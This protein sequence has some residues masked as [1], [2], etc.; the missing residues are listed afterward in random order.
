MRTSM[1]RRKARGS[2]VRWTGALAAVAVGLAAGQSAAQDW[3]WLGGSSA[4][5]SDLANWNSAA[6]GSGSA[7]ASTAALQNKTLMLW[8]TKPNLPSNQDIESLAVSQ[9]RFDDTVTSFTITGQPIQLNDKINNTANPATAQTVTFNNVV[10]L[11]STSAWSVRGNTRF[12]LVGGMQEVGGSRYFSANDGGRIGFF[13]PVTTTGGWRNNQATA[14]FHGMETLGTFPATLNADY[15]RTGYG[16]MQF[17]SPDGAPYEYELPATVGGRSTTTLALNVPTDVVVIFHGP[18][19]EDAANRSVTKWGGGVLYL[20]GTNTFTGSISL[21][22]GMLVLGGPLSAGDG[23]TPAI[24]TTSG[25]L[26]L[27]GHDV[28]GRRLTFSNPSGFQSS[29]VLRNSNRAVASTLDGNMTTVAN[30]GSIVQ[31]GGPGAIRWT[32]DLTYASSSYRICK[33]GA[34][35]LTFAGANTAYTGPWHT[36]GG[37]LVLDYASNNGG[38]IGDSSLVGLHGNLSVLGNAAAATVET[39]GSLQVGR[40]ANVSANSV[41]IAVAGSG[42]QTATL[43]FSALDVNGN[44]TVDFAPGAG[45]SIRSTSATNHGNIG[46]VAM[47]ATF[48]GSSYAHV[49]ATPDGDGYREIEGLPDGAYA[50]DFDVGTNYEIVDVG[51]GLTL[52]IAETAAALRFN[53]ATPATLT[54]DN[55]LNLNGEITSNNGYQGAILVTPNVGANDT[56]IAGSGILG[57]NSVNG[58]LHVHQHNTAAPLTISARINNYSSGSSLSK[59]G[60]GELVLSNANNSFSTLSVFDG[61]LTLPGITNANVSCPAGSGSSVLLGTATIRYTGPEAGTDRLI[62]LR[63]HGTIESAG[64][65]KLTFTRATVVSTMD[66]NDHELTLTGAGDGEIQGK[67]DLKVGS[68]VKAGAG[69]WTLAASSTNSFWGGARVDAGTLVVDGVLGRDVA[70]GVGGTLAG[71]GSIGHS[72]TVDGTLAVDL[73]AGSLTVAKHVDLDGATLVVT[74]VAGDEPIAALTCGGTLT[75]TFANVSEGYIAT[76]TGTEVLI[77]AA[78]PS[79]M[80]ILVR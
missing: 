73:A 29:G 16:T 20:N 13:G 12:E 25:T 27:N 36:Y 47:R 55:H 57:L 48:R 59:S 46:A 44:C 23:A 56:V 38:K 14:V 66:G 72:L 17:N 58:W 80:V 11:N 18:I 65:G 51:A 5:W 71:S 40:L 39:V 53:A 7:P 62:N 63:G 24:G 78:P 79:G 21:Q 69:T 43:R 54:L 2:L 1:S 42:G 8:T 19:S 50:A 28:L 67:L 22:D 32:G 35:T 61:T 49:A 64:T 9:L 4:N 41:R 10:V 75:G 60:P 77:T 30:S 68:L 52:G 31:F 37:L 45:D 33:T 26:D 70:V 6:D 76:Y 3:Y 34:G 15:F 74:G